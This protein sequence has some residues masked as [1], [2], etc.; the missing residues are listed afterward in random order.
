MVKC[1]FSTTY[2]TR[3]TGR[4]GGGIHLP[5]FFP[6]ASR[7]FCFLVLPQ[8]PSTDQAGKP[9]LKFLSSAIHA[10]ALRELGRQQRESGE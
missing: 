4:F 10:H 6:R 3:Q 7:P 8:G 1:P 5:S 2:R 9:A